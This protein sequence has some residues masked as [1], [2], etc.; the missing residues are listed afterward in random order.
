MLP[1]SPSKES[2]ECLPPEDRLALG[3]GVECEVG[4]GGEDFSR[5]IF[6][7]EATLP[8]TCAQ[9]VETV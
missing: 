1:V 2:R 9:W 7:A 6:F 4:L 3:F 5:L 8:L